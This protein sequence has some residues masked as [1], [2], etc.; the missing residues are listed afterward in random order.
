MTAFGKI[1]G[2]DLRNEGNIENP[3]LRITLFSGER[4][5]NSE[6][7]YFQDEIS[8]RYGLNED[9]T[10]FVKGFQYDEILEPVI[11]RWKGMRVSCVY[12]L[13]ELAIVTVVLQNTNVSRSTLMLKSLLQKYGR[14][15]CLGKYRLYGFWEPHQII[16]VSEK[17]LRDL[18]L[19]YRAKFIREISIAFA[20][21]TIDENELK[22]T[23]RWEAKRQLM[24][25]KGI[26]PV[27]AQILLLEY[28]RYYDSIEYIPP[29]DR[30][31]YSKLILG[32]E[33]ASSEEILREAKRRWGKWAGLAMHYLWEDIFWRRQKGE[34]M[35]WLEKLLRL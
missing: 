25:L 30:K 1:F 2:V 23:G 7:K 34:K 11:Q 29:W 8:W 24:K 18:K 6:I 21:K 3:I 27:S 32:K 20:N 10:E 14:K 28:L 22:I 26:G 4:L 13:Y 9:I 35:E 19:G 16:S 17:D 15:A 31:I 12:S 33:D 5:S